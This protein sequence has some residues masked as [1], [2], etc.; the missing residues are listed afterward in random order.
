MSFD[1]IIG[2]NK[3]KAFFNRI[4]ESNNIVHSYMFEGTCGIGKSLFAREFAKMILCIGDNKKTCKDCKSCLEFNSNNNPDFNQIQ[5][6]G[7]VIKIEQI[8]QM[9]EKI[10]EKPI[11]SNKKVYIINDADLMTKE[12]Q[13]CLLKTLEEP[14]KYIVI[15]L[16]LSNESKIL[17]TVKSRCMRII[18]EKIKK[19]EL[20][21]YADRNFNKNEI[22]KNIIENCNGS[23]AKLIKIKD[24]IEQYEKIED[25]AEKFRTDNILDI[26]NN[27]DILYKSKDNIDDML[28]YMTTIFYKL[29]MQ[30]KNKYNYINIINEIEKTRKRIKANNNFDMSIDHLIFKI[31]EEINEDSNRSQV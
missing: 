14:P 19:D 4:I 23:I 18:F 16:V 12:A 24:N 5:P 29:F 11:I 7:K 20:E 15:I 27:A 3:N 8:R 13:N 26:I 1:N 21:Q 31:W 25:L 10:L 6:E 9:Q 17:N 30:E 2:N 28:D 22:T